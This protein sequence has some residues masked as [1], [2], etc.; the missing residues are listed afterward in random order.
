M[1][2]EYIDMIVLWKRK[3]ETETRTIHDAGM[4]FSKTN[5]DLCDEYSFC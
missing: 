4:T 1:S 5:E 3:T 2:E